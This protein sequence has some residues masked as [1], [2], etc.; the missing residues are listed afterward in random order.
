MLQNWEILITHPQKRN[1]IRPFAA[2]QMDL[3]IVILSEV[4]QTEEG[5]GHMIPLIRGI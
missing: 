5:K 3:E 1:E 4:S 2:T